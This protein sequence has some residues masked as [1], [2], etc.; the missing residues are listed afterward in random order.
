MPA[1]TR[2]AGL[3]GDP[4]EHS[5]SPHMHNAAFRSIGLDARYEL[6]PTAV[7][8]LAIRVTSLRRENMLG[9]NI[10]V[11]YKQAVMPLLDE[12]SDIARR[13]GAVNTI[14]LR[15]GQLYG[16]NT[17]AYGFGRS[18]GEATGH[19]VPACVL[20]VGAGGA[21]R[22]VLVSLQDAGVGE[23]VLVN[24]TRDKA[25]AMAG[26][27]NATGRPV[28]RVHPWTA[29]PGLAGSVNV[30]VNATSIGW[31]GED[32]P[33]AIDVIAGLPVDAVAMDLTYRSTAMLRAASARGLRAVDGLSMLVYQGARSFESWTG[34]PA[35]VDDM[36]RAVLA[37][38]ARR[39]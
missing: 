37:E 31:R 6:W 23:I 4:V 26:S 2:I 38:Q 29:L 21:S 14:I 13:V 36:R 27:L 32:L 25:D 1:T 35:P 10:T 5:L 39:S 22:A 30:L 20:V 17:D 34:Q 16:D 33:F 18:L 7:D 11:P 12:L 28:I 19:C 3:I 15:D 24:R 9:A 8:D